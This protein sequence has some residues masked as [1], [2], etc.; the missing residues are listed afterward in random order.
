MSHHFQ[1]KNPGSSNGEMIKKLHS[2]H[3][4]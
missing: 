1:K 2:K 4:K 3:I